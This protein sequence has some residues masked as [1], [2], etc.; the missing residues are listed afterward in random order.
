[1]SPASSSGSPVRLRHELD[2]EDGVGFV[3]RILAV[4]LVV[5]FVNL[6]PL[7][8]LTGTRGPLVAAVLVPV[9]VILFPRAVCRVVLEPLGFVRTAWWL[10]RYFPPLAMLRHG[11]SAAAIEASRVLAGRCTDEDVGY[12][13]LLARVPPCRTGWAVVANAE[14]HAAHGDTGRARQLYLG[15]LT[16][17]RSAVHE[18]ARRWLQADAARRG[19]WPLVYAYGRPQRAG[20]TSRA[21]AV[22]SARHRGRP[23]EHPT[24]LAWHILLSPYRFVLLTRLRKALPAAL[25]TPL[26][27]PSATLEGA[28]ALHAQV[29]RRAPETLG[30]DDLERLG[31]AWDRVA[32]DEG[33]LERLG[34]RSAIVGA[35]VTPQS[36]RLELLADV[37]RDLVG[38][39]DQG[40]R[41]D[42]DRETSGVLERARDSA[43]QSRMAE[44][45]RLLDSLGGD[46]H[47]WSDGES[48][49]VRWGEVH[50]AWQAVIAVSRHH[51][52]QEAFEAGWGAACNWA[53]DL[54]NEWPQQQLAHEI[55][56]TLHQEVMVVDGS[57]VAESLLQDNV[58]QTR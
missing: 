20:A 52:R 12:L 15:L 8:L 22:V 57:V 55:F 54:Y 53:A 14:L 38:L 10:N 13:W 23:I 16:S 36:I 28:V 50:A 35:R 4:V 9:F 56:H 24:R 6:G 33:L 46:E 58:Q 26:A 3:L 37:E 11:R 45:E 51:D 49:W 48:Y 25:A 41:I 44:L 2:V 19:E 18:R 5:A 21:L 30:H 7:R 1:A 27:D 39:F 42:G 17:Q 32:D 31:A 43:W 34:R 47:S 29:L 40:V